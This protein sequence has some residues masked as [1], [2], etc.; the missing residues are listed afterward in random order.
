MRA[1]SKNICSVRHKPTPSAP[2]SRAV[3]AVA[4]RLGI[5][6]HLE[7]ALTPSAQTI[8][9]AEVAGEL[10]LHGRHFAEP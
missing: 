6:A 8:E 7:A 10:G 1:P 9:S 5:G 2:N 3:L 4:R